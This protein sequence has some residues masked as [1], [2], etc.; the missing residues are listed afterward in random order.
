M[1]DSPASRD[2]LCPVLRH[3]YEVEPCDPAELDPLVACLKQGERLDADRVFPRGTM[4]RDGRLDLCKQ[5]L[6]PGGAGRVLES[7]SGSGPVSSILLGTDGIGDEGARSVARAIRRRAGLRT[8]YLGCN[9]ITA[10]GA[11][12]IVRAI[13]ETRATR[14]L[15]LKRNPIGDEGARAVAAML[16]LT[17]ELRTL[18]LLDCAIG[19]DGVVALVDALSE[20]AHGLRHLYLAGNSIGPRG[21]ERLSHWL[22]SDPALEGLYIGLMPVGDDGVCL[23]ARGLAAN[24]QL[25]T[26]GLRSAGL[27]PDA[28]V[29]LGEA[30]GRHPALAVLDLGYARS[31]RVLGLASNRLECAGLEGLLPV[32]RPGSALRSL[33]L[34]G[35][36]VGPRGAASLARA[37]EDQDQLVHL[38]LGPGIPGWTRRIIRAALERNTAMG[39]AVP[40]NPD[41]L[42]V[43]STYR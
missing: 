36:G 13:G 33:D 14:A 22:A 24:S 12:E 20:T 41:G 37:L 38:R 2:P 4:R 26:L 19:D 30:L 8:V 23:L 10:E 1:S 35:N 39:D 3:S 40:R 11:A 43:L 6:G 17:P 32:L 18:D 31:T 21:L 15:W 7:I 9:G 5:S 28:G 16:R 27:G 34:G 29:V 25:T 42:D